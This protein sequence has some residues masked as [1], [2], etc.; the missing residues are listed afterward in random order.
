MQLRKKIGPVT[1]RALSA[2]VLSGSLGPQTRR[3][4]NIG[5]SK[6]HM[7][8]I[9]TRLSGTAHFSLGPLELGTQWLRVR[10]KNSR[11]TRR[12][13]TA[14]NLLRDDG[15][16]REQVLKTGATNQTHRCGEECVR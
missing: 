2:T 12:E 14:L 6:W 4:L 3:F 10:Y 8:T 1:I 7:T 15:K 9:W 16:R 5:T 11:L 13:R